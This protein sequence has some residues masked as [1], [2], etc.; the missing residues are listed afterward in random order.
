MRRKM[1]Y[2][3]RA[4]LIFYLAFGG[5]VGV[6]AIAQA[7]VDHPLSPMVK[8]L[9]VGLGI[10]VCYIIFR[11]HAAVATWTY[12]RLNGNKDRS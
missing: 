3:G 12:R 6:A 5:L 11:F 8:V 4:F 7:P 9:I 2:L 10:L 1:T